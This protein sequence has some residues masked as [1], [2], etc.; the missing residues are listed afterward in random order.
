LG[1]TGGGRDTWKRP[2][3]GKIAEA[4]CDHII[5]TNE[6]PYDEDPRAIVE[7]MSTGIEDKSKLTIIMDR[8]EAIRHAL[9]TAP[10]GG[11]VLISG[12]GTDPY[13]MGPNNSRIPWSDARVVEEELAKLT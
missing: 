5:L 6:D 3:M 1:N 13:I 12:K 11:Y 10:D 7:A 2:E 9:H 8:R 4:Y